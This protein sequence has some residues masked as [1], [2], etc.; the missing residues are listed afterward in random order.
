MLA[1]APIL[2]RNSYVPHKDGKAKW[3][4]LPTRSLPFSTYTPTD[5]FLKQ[6]ED[7]RMHT[8]LMKFGLGPGGT[9]QL[10]NGDVDASND[11]AVE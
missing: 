5:V 7:E 1:S 9:G 3:K 4:P 11:G 2:A 8:L 10:W 6:K